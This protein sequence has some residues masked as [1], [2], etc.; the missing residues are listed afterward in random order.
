M[1]EV[2]FPEENQPEFAATLASWQYLFFKYR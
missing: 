2:P 1:Q